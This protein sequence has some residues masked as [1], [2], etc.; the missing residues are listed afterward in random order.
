MA[1]ST[2]TLRIGPPSET[3]EQPYNASSRSEDSAIP[4]KRRWRRRAMGST[5]PQ[6][7]ASWQAENPAQ[8]IRAHFTPAGGRCRPSLVMELRGVSA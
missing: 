3:R 4:Y 5:E 2:A 7:L 8:Q 6:Q 1:A